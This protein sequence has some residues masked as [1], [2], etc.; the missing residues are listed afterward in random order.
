LFRGDEL[1][2][3]LW[4]D[5]ARSFDDASL[6]EQDSPLIVAFAGFRVSEFRGF[7][8]SIIKPAIIQCYEL[9]NSDFITSSH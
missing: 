2:I 6:A 4:G 3:T 8:R 7:L 9:F 1:R 5:I